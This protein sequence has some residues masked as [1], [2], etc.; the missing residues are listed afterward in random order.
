MSIHQRIRTLRKLK[1]WTQAELAK[2][3]SER[4]RIEPPLTR[5]AVA[6]WET[7]SC[8]PAYD[9]L[10]I[11]AAVLGISVQD[12]LGQPSGGVVGLQQLRAAMPLPVQGTLRGGKDGEQ[13]LALHREPEGFVE[14]PTSDPG[15]YA[16]RLRGDAHEPRLLGG[17]ILVLEPSYGPRCGDDVLVRM[18]DGRHLLRMYIG[19]SAGHLQLGMLNEDYGPLTLALKDVEVIHLVGGH[20]LQRSKKTH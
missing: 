17:E 14:F 15:A 9:R 3:V 19:R 10:P 11:V 6:Q 7:E 12:L 13:I 5:N 2:R 1:G 20:L 4:E 16:L 8:V 18:T